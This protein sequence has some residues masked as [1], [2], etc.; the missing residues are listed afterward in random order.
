VLIDELLVVCDDRLGDGLADGV[1]LGSVTASGDPDADVDTGELVEADNQEGL[2]DLES[3]NLG[4]DQVERLAVDL[5]QSLTSLFFFS[6]VSSPPVSLVV[7]HTLQW[8][9]AVAVRKFCQYGD[10]SQARA[11][12]RHTCLL[13]AEALH[14]LGCRCHVCDWR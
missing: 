11:A 14:T 6:S 1:D 9:T 3:Q 4:L 10:L 8:A 7:V 2:V 13:L 12:S 5:N